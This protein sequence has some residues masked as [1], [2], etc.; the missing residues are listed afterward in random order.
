VKLAFL[1]LALAILF[2][3][4]S[5]AGIPKYGCFIGDCAKI[6]SVTLD[7]ISFIF[8]ALFFSF[9]CLKRLLKNSE[10]KHLN[11]YGSNDLGNFDG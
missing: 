6:Y 8:F 7:S 1:Y 11:K 2:G 3:F 5:F 10:T 4:V 9:L